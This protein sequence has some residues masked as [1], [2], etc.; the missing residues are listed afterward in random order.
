[1]GA[2]AMETCARRSERPPLA[3]AGRWSGQ[4]WSGQR[5]EQGCT[6]GIALLLGIV[7]GVS[8]VCGISVVGGVSALAQDTTASHPRLEFCVN[9][10]S[11]VDAPERGGTA[12]APWRTLTF[13]FARAGLALAQ[14]G[15]GVA[16]TIVLQEG[17]YGEDEQFP[18]TLPET[19]GRVTLDG[20]GA[21][22]IEVPDACRPLIVG[23]TDVGMKL[24]LVGLTFRGRA[25]EVPSGVQS[26]LVL[27]GDSGAALDVSVER[28][29]F[30]DTIVRA[31]DVSVGRGGGCVVT[32][33][34][35][36]FH[37]RG[38]G[39]GL[40]ALEGASFL[41][42]VEGCRFDGVCRGET[43]PSAAVEVHCD[44]DSV[45]EVVVERNSFHAL[46]SAVQLTCGTPAPGPVRLVARVRGNL[47]ENLADPLYLSL[48]SE[49]DLDLLIAQNTI[50]G[51][52][53][54]VVFEDNLT[55]GSSFPAVAWIFANNVCYDVRGV[56]EFA[57][58][59]RGGALE[60]GFASQS[61]TG[62]V[63]VSNRLEK[64]ALIGRFGNVG[65]APD[66]VR[67]GPLCVFDDV[68]PPVGERGDWRLRE[69][70]PLLGLG[71][72]EYADGLGSDLDGLCR[73]SATHCASKGESDFTVDLGA[74]E[75]PGFCREDFVFLRGDCSA[76]GDVVLSDFVALLNYLF[77]GH[78]APPCPDACD[79]DDDGELTLVDSVR[80]LRFL[81]LGHAPPAPPGL[82][83]GVDPTCDLLAP[84]RSAPVF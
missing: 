30:S 38:A 21:S 7:C 10:R 29:T 74:Y 51:V 55:S 84:C 22:E 13:A 8:V 81:F 50:V 54:F 34:D 1:M 59:W 28:C 35:S 57:A 18:L 15:H 64:S 25:S 75:E 52:E 17:L 79:T 12:L 80:G 76:S 4:G 16:L 73:F 65:D 47:M 19:I 66:F 2:L 60:E 24:S 11:G 31:L 82:G 43:V 9:A 39:I 67:P 71:L 45:G 14:E 78:Q 72:S 37:G 42:S 68:N 53:R 23:N 32:V 44:G 83:G 49:H 5:G 46:S 63:V 6:Q 58:E 33:R 26:A 56:S 36:A 3:R 77:L 61:G 40:E 62:P 70:S 41:L 27:A 20:G 48:S 69:D